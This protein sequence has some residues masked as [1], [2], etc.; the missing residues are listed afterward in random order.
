M[1]I[2]VEIVL[3]L[4]G[5]AN[6]GV[7][8]T[9]AGVGTWIVAAA[10]VAGKPI[11]IVLAAIVG[12][13]FGAALP[14]AMSRGDLFVIGC[15]AGIG[16]TVAL[17]FCTAAFPDGPVLDQTKIGAL[18]SFAAAPIATVAALVLGVGRFARRRA[19]E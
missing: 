4:F 2:P 7:P 11:G 12:Q 6:A 18:L 1:R 5:L 13:Q 19:I 10:L 9:R 8:F 17:F 14:S 15:V 3:F 16:F